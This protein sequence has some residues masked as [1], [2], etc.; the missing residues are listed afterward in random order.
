MHVSANFEWRLQLQHVG[1]RKEDLSGLG[2][3]VLQIFFGEIH[4]LARLLAPD[5]KQLHY[6]GVYLLVF[7]LHF[8][9]SVHAISLTYY[10]I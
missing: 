5:F 7:D 2:A 4:L 8:C 9:I 3:E 10:L 1:L 6:H